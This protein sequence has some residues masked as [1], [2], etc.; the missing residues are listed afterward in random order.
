MH[1]KYI[2][3]QENEYAYPMS[4]GFV[5]FLTGYVHSDAKPRP[6][7]VVAP[8]GAYCFVAPSEGGPVAESF[9]ECGFWTA[10]AQS[11]VS[12]SARAP[13][14]RNLSGNSWRRPEGSRERGRHT[15]TLFL[16]AMSQVPCLHEHKANI[17]DLRM[18]QGSMPRPLRRGY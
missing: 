3:W 15:P 1:E 10:R 2:L 13:C 11:G 16:R 4:G 14:R 17:V 6:A 18:P 9:Y 7:M 8:G 12:A 5:P